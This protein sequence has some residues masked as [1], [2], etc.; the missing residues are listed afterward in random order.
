M[1]SG[2]NTIIAHDLGL[3]RYTLVSKEPVNRGGASLLCVHAS[4]LA[5][6]RIKFEFHLSE[7]NDGSPRLSE[8]SVLLEPGQSIS[9][10]VKLDSSAHSQERP[11]YFV[12]Q[13]TSTVRGKEFEQE[14]FALKL[15]RG[16]W[17]A[18][19][20]YGPSGGHVKDDVPYRSLGKSVV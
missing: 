10:Y 20:P 15:G 8:Q 1:G 7:R 12:G 14:Q 13:V 3:T 5:S 18:S 16:E 2:Q 17:G 19:E 6:Q 11:L 4:S 9:N